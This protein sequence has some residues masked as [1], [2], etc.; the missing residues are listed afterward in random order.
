MCGV[1]PNIVLVY[2]LGPGGRCLPA[3]YLEKSARFHSEFRLTFFWLGEGV[4]W[5]PPS[6]GNIA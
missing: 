1:I 3:Q 6:L 2:F 5:K 4:H